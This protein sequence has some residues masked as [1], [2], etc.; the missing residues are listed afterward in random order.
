MRY[1]TDQMHERVAGSVVIWYDSVLKDGS[2][3][4]QNELNND[5]RQVRKIMTVKMIKMKK[6]GM[7]MVMIAKKSAIATWWL[8]R[9]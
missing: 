3:K 6:R 4:W 7:I 1:L 2:L 9:L 5:N 8:A